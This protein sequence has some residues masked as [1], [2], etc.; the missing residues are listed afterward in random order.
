MV[1]GAPWCW[2]VLGGGVGWCWVVLGGVPVGVVEHQ[3]VPVGLQRGRYHGVE[4]GLL[5]QPLIT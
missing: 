3:G 5:Q 4:Q 1:L 2:V